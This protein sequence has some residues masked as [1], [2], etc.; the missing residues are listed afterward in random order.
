M[1]ELYPD[2]KFAHICFVIV[3]GSI[4]SLR[5]LL[6]LAGSRYSHHPALKWG[7]YIN[8]SLLLTA[9][10]ML[11]TII[12]QY[13]IAQAWLS[14]KLSLLVVYI[15]L[16]IFAL[17][18]GQTRQQRGLYFIAAIATYALMATIAY[19]HRALGFLAY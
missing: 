3:S 18:L 10:L 9:G 14:A 19:T 13:P 17:R 6:M 15:V 7:S 2:I 16:G 5:G 11:M 8:D 12:H 1:I 4:F